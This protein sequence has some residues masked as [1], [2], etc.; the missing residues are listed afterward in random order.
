MD[1]FQ[2]L[3]L[4][5]QGVIAYS[6][7]I[8][9]TFFLAW[10]SYSLADKAYQRGIAEQIISTLWG[11]VIFIMGL[12]VYQGAL[13]VL[14]TTAYELSKQYLAG[15]SL[16]AMSLLILNVFPNAYEQTEVMWT[17][18][19]MVVIFWLLFLARVLW[20]TWVEPQ[21]ARKK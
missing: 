8:F 17:D 18:E 11:V 3:A 10:V 20:T 19:L 14:K 7:L 12:G 1:E 6:V 2:L 4:C 9:S 15:K 16:S 13:A 21:Q 5:Y